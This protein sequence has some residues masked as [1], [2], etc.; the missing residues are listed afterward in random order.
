MK[1]L[2]AFWL[3]FA[4]AATV[5]LAVFA[6]AA[7]V[8]R[9]PAHSYSGVLAEVLPSVVSI[10][11]KTGGGSGEAANL[12]AGVVINGDGH[13]ITNY[14]LVANTRQL[15]VRLKDDSRHNA[16]IA[17]VDPEIDIAVLKIQPPANLKALPV[18]E[19]AAPGDI[20]F[21]IGHPYGLDGSA[22]MG[23]VS[24]V[25][26]DRLLL[27]GYDGEKLIQT[28]A[29]INPGNSG[30]PL[31]NTKGELVGINTALYSRRSGAKAQGIGF[32]VPAQLARYSYLSLTAGERPEKD[33]IGALVRPLPARLRERIRNAA[34]NRESEG[35]KPSSTVIVAR[36]W[37]GTIAEARGLKIGDILVGLNE[38]QLEFARDNNALPP[39]TKTVQ[40]LRHNEKQTI[41][42]SP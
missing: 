2:R 27:T 30:G 14:H 4:Q 21:A 19:E 32:A 31:T 35:E 13:I 23:I 29:A 42:L 18:A 5:A 22:S 10:H 8:W 40:I 6:V 37:R 38:T 41:T 7:L 24:A 17:G 1:R 34:G 12:G 33:A 28:D 9:P 25:G 15:K 36:I 11:G 20:V 3:L 39:E 26:R 16:D